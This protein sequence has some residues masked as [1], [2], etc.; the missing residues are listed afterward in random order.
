MMGHPGLAALTTT[1]D[2]LI[3]TPQPL[4]K[5]V[6][7]KLVIYTSI[8]I[9]YTPAFLE[10]YENIQTPRCEQRQGKSAIFNPQ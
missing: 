4:Q 9:N 1:G 10:F 8:T 3:S 5:I 7:S 6:S 2:Q